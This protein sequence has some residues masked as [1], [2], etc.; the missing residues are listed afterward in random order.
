MLR[1]TLR[2]A[3][4]V[5]L[6]LALVAALAAQ[7]KPVVPKPLTDAQKEK[8]KDR[9]GLDAEMKA[10]YKEGKLNETVAAGEKML[11]LERG[12]YGDAHYIVANRLLMLAQLHEQREDIPAARKAMTAVAKIRTQLYGPD[13]WAVIETRR[14]LEHYDQLERLSPADRRDLG[15]SA[16]LL[17]QS[18]VLGRER[19]FKEAISLA[20]EGVEI[21]KRILGERHSGYAVSIWLL[22]NLHEA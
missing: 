8:L 3:A 11:A 2:A 6:A 13:H 4:A 15:R 16:G 9:D 10:L 20:A 22:G 5:F 12:V 7:P 19:K 1:T 14:D 21:E 17:R 18:E